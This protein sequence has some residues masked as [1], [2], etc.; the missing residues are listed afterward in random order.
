MRPRSLAAVPLLI[1][2]AAAAAEAK[3]VFTPPVLTAIG[4]TASCVVQNVGT[5]TRNVTVTI[6]DNM[7]AAIV[8]NMVDVD[9][10]EVLS[11]V[12]VGDAGYRVYCKFDGLSSSVRGFLEL[13]DGPIPQLVVPAGK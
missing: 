13:S 8:G 9:P 10:G 1:A 11:P 2:L 5:K 4:A 12:S 6:H 7:G 3:P